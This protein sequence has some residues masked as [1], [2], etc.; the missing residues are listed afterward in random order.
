MTGQTPAPAQEAKKREK[1]GFKR[2]FIEIPEAQYK[3][4][5]EWA[6]KNDREGGASEAARVLMKRHFDTLIGSKD[7]NP[8][9]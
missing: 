4:L 7:E 9:S 5:E 3:K 2:L 1:P 6:V 8:T